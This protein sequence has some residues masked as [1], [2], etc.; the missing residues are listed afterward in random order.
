MKLQTAGLEDVRGEVRRLVALCKP[1]C[2]DLTREDVLE[3][4]ALTLWERRAKEYDS[5]SLHLIE[6]CLWL[7]KR[8]DI[9]TGHWLIRMWPQWMLSEARRLAV[10][11]KGADN[12]VR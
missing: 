5:W 8:G 3:W 12:A 11:D 9:G 1:L 4:E 10:Q 6:A 2:P 7:G